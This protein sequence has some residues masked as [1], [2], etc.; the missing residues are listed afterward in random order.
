M[1]SM[2]DYSSAIQLR[3]DRWSALRAACAALT[4][5]PNDTEK[6]KLLARVK[7]LFT[8]LAVIEPYWAFPGMSAF[9]HLRRQFDHS[10]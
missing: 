9:D 8:S 5:S 1:H 6:E 2:K 7:E 4:R 10:N 3:S